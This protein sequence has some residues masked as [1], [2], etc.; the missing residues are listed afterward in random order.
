VI[1]DD[2]KG[3]YKERAILYDDTNVEQIKA[4]PN[5]AMH[6]QVD[7]QLVAADEAGERLCVFECTP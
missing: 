6:R 1:I 3:Y 4:I 2:S 5:E 7:L